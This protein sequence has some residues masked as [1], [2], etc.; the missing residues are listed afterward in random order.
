MSGEDEP[1][2]AEH[3]QFKRALKKARPLPTV[4]W[5]R[6]MQHIPSP[7]EIHALA[8]EK[9][10]YREERKIPELLC[11]VHSEVSE[12]L[13]GYRSGKILTGHGCVAEEL[14]DIV[15]RV[16]DMAAYL[17]IPIGKAIAKKHARNKKRPFR[18][19]GKQC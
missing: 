6:A 7:V 3:E 12:A 15:I 2:Q 14:A 16:F 8:I 5:W 13:E 11:L 18:H 10:W 19:G 4:D 17:K 9:G 1:K